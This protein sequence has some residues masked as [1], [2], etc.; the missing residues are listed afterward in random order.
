MLQSSCLL[1][2]YA[3]RY[4]KI[5]LCG[6]QLLPACGKKRIKTLKMDDKRLSFT[7]GWMLSAG[8]P[9]ALAIETKFRKTYAKSTKQFI[10]RSCSSTFTAS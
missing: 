3:A 2:I 10:W 5:I 1:L 4:L 7:P 9:I 8:T 6:M